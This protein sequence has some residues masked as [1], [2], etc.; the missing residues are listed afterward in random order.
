MTK[1]L[2]ALHSPK[3]GKGVN[4]LRLQRKQEVWLRPST[5]SSH[6]LTTSTDRGPGAGP[7]SLRHQRYQ[8]M[9]RGTDMRRTELV[10]CGTV[11]R[12]AAGETEAC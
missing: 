6:R 12:D 3:E 7:A 5:F 9:R 2:L 11:S 1:L 10:A 4:G 8:H